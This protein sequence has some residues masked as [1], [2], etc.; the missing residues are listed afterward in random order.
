MSCSPYLWIDAVANLMISRHPE[1][2]KI[3]LGVHLGD[4]D[5]RAFLVTRCFD[6]ILHCKLSCIFTVHDSKVFRRSGLLRDS[7]GFVSIPVYQFDFDVN[8]YV[9]A[10]I[11]KTEKSRKA[12]FALNFSFRINV[13]GILCNILV[14]ELEGKIG[15]GSHHCS[16]C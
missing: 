3:Q 14:T 12:M 13:D 11:I 15:G 7:F 6:S 16:Q 1:I 9:I 5:D 8:V 10:V 4:H 2:S